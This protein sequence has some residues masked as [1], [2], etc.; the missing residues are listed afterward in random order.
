V[1][2]FKSHRGGRL[3]VTFTPIES[4][5]LSDL[6]GQVAELLNQ[7][8]P[9]A[10]DDDL[11]A[12]VGMGGSTSL[13]D[14]PAIARLLP[15]AYRDDDDAAVDF[16]RFTEGGLAGRKVANAELVVASLGDCDGDRIELDATQ[17]QAWLKTIND[18]RL[19]LAARMGIENDEDLDEDDVAGAPEPDDEQTLMLRDVYD[20]LAYVQESL[21]HALE[22]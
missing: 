9:E 15:D 11:A 4:R 21:L 8:A 14:D 22:G 5:L 7:H 17:T 16:R 19:T 10:T 6:A 2:P 13:S 1:K 12:Q 20:W 3:T 18:I